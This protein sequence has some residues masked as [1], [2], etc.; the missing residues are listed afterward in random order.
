MFEHLVI[1]GRMKT[2]PKDVDSPM[3]QMAEEEKTSGCQTEGGGGGDFCSLRR[4]DQLVALI[5]I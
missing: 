5:K 3:S 1:I 2:L 4:G